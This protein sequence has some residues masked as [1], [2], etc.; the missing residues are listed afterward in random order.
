[1]RPHYAGE[2]YLV[3]VSVQ[4][5]SPGCVSMTPNQLHAH[6]YSPDSSH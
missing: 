1:M 4:P 5:C 3:V 6:D 2:P